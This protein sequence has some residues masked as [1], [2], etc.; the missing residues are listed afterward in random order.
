MSKIIIS[1]VGNGMGCNISRF[2]KSK[3]HELGI[4]S[5]GDV[6]ENVA[7]ALGAF[8]GRC[9]LL[10]FENTKNTFSEIVHHLGKL[11]GV[12]HLAGGYFGKKMLKK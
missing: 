12:V 5:R 11:D 4:L 10:D 7:K 3:S 1:G 2:L 6:G 9:N 8:Y